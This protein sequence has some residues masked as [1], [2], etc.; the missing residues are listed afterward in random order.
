MEVTVKL[1]HKLKINCL[2][3]VYGQDLSLWEENFLSFLRNN[4]ILTTKQES[5]LNE[6]WSF[7]RSG[8]LHIEKKESEYG[9]YSEEFGVSYDDIHDFDK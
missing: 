1:I 5:K 9:P 7:F 6:I 2:L 4:K 8:K 3:S